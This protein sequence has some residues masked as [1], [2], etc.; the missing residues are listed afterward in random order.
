MRF[1]ETESE[2]ANRIARENKRELFDILP[3]LK[4]GAEKGPFLCCVCTDEMT[5]NDDQICEDCQL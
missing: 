2:T 1:F 3:E 4:K 5:C